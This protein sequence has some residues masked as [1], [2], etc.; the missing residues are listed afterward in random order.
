MD[1]LS[2]RALGKADAKQ[3]LGE[4]DRCE[5]LTK[6]QRPFREFVTILMNNSAIRKSVSKS[7]LP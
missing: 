5:N 1:R 6:K 3:K 4:G 7:V 2:I